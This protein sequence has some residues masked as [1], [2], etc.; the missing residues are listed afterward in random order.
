MADFFFFTD[1][2]LLNDQQ[3]NQAFG[4]AGTSGGSDVFNVTSKHT[5]TADSQAYAICKGVVFIQDVIGN[6]DLVNL[7]L[8]PIDQ[9]GIDFPK[10]KYFIYRGILKSQLINGSD[11]AAKSTN[12]L[13]QSLW[14]SQEARNRSSNTTGN[15]PKEALGID[16]STSLAGSDSIDSVFYRSTAEYQFPV[17]SAGWRLG[18]FKSTGFSIEVMVER[19]GFDRTLEKVRSNNNVIAV[20]TLTASP[21]QAQAFE[22]WH[23]KEEILNYIDPCAFFG[24]LYHSKVTVRESSGHSE[25]R[26]G[27]EL[28]DN[29]LTRFYN[30]NVTYLD[31]RN[32]YNYSFNYFKNYGPNIKIATDDSSNPTSSR[33]YY[34]DKWPILTVKGNEF[35]TGNNN[36]YNVIRIAL[37]DGNGDNSFP[38]IYISSGFINKNIRKGPKETNKL[39]ESDIINGFTQDIVLTVPNRNDSVGTTPIASYTKLKYFKRFNP[40]NNS[41]PVPSSGTVI[42]STNFMDNIFMLFS[43]KVPFIGQSTIKVAVYDE[44]VYID[45]TKESGVSFI[46]SAGISIDATHTT[47]FIFPKI[48]KH[49]DPDQ[50]NVSFFANLATEESNVIGNFYDLIL[51][52]DRSFQLIKTNLS[53]PSGTKEAIDLSL[54]NYSPPDNRTSPT[55]EFLLAV[56][57]SN[58]DYNAWR[59]QSSSTFI[60]KYLKVLGATGKESGIDSAGQEYTAYSLKTRGYVLSSGTLTV[61]EIDHNKKTFANA[62]LQF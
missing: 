21:T 2:D 57:I 18:K 35:P 53:I 30:K 40:D 31:I 48:L 60:A 32:E 47:L 42:R 3:Q 28:Y 10:I 5:A 27:N 59:T 46:G 34:Q 13:T 26:K 14:N 20:T 9:P 50:S 51:S 12:D 16:L 54:Q 15:P 17:V 4:P 36:D 49:R 25:N 23:D 43:M 1:I 45:L 22:H 41:I 58:T 56:S 33:D 62:S 19:I 52:K 38:L 6:S 11:I 7:I 29:V 8:K 55:L 44:E 24:M 37:P 39:I 61:S